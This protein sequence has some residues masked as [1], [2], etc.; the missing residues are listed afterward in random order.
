MPVEDREYIV[1]GFGTAGD[2]K[3]FSSMGTKELA[4]SCAKQI[5]MYYKSVRIVD[6]ETVDRLLD[7]ERKSRM[8]YLF[9]DYVYG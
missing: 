6:R 7:E 3:H 5:R 1:L 8:K 9:G 2:I 4:Q